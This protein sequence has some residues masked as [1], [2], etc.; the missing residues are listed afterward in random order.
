MRSNALLL[1]SGFWLLA[2]VAPLAAR[3]APAPEPA[4]GRPGQ[5]PSAQRP[6][7]P[8]APTP[9]GGQPPRMEMATQVPPGP[10]RLEPLPTENVKID[11]TITD[12][13]GTGSKKTVSVLV[14]GGRNGRVRSQNG[15]AI[16]NVDARPE[17]MR[18]GRILLSLTL[19]YMTTNTQ[20]DGPERPAMINES[21]SAIVADGK[22]VVISQSAD[23]CTDR[24]VTVEVMA[25]IL[26]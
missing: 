19:E 15:T 26:K 3:Q 23:P 6:N 1:A 9:P 18:D 16:L 21:M 12:T 5:A 13:F 8:P 22:S 11:L 20:A 4:Q 25:T 7:M 14:A 2:S 17:T 24:K 10:P